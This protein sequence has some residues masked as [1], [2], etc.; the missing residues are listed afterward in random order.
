MKIL[1]LV[2]LLIILSLFNTN[3][4]SEETKKDCDSIEKDTL[5]N[6]YEKWRCKRS[7]GTA[8]PL[9]KKIKNLFKKKN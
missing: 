5:I 2:P 7:K 3:S 4:I 8:E 1:K 6:I 9:G